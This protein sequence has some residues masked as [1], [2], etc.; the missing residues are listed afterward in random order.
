MSKYK[1]NFKADIKL[2]EVGDIEPHMM[3]DILTLR[4]ESDGMT[5]EDA[6]QAAQIARPEV[7]DSLKGVLDIDFSLKPVTMDMI[8]KVEK[9]D[10]KA[11]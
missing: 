1:V 3:T 11:T 2:E 5:Q 9:F 8:E 10:V 4:L 7:E 6:M